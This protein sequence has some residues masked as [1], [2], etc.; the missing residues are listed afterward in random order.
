M[1]ATFE[2][3]ATTTLGTAASSI[4]F[5]SISAAYTDLR[6]VLVCR[7]SGSGTTDNAREV[8]LRDIN[9][10]SA[11]LSS[12]TILV[13]NGSAASS[14]RITNSDYNLIG[15]SSCAADTAGVFTLITTDIFN[16]A[17]STFKTMLSTCSM[18]L[19]GSGQAIR[20]V[21]LWRSTSA[22]SSFT[23]LPGNNFVAGTT[24]TLYGILRA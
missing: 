5:S 14:T 18:D 1:A 13:G 23:L 8:Q 17:G 21:N 4:T 20:I 19:N 3:I 16:Y 10:G 12:D 9:G 6:L 22:I 2:P 7:N 15:R 24:A 11:S